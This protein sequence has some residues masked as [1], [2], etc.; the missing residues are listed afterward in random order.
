V[1]MAVY[2]KAIQ[3]VK[4]SRWL[5]AEPASESFSWYG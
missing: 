4:W 2:L 3:K 5:A 1:P